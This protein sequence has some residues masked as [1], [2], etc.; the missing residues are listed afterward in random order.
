VS[1]LGIAR[2]LRGRRT[3]GEIEFLCLPEDRGVIAEPVPARTVQPAWFKA[4]PGLDRAALSATNNGLT[5]KRCVPFLDALSIGWIL[6]LA[7]TVRLEI[8]DGGRSVTAGWE[9]DREMVSPHGAH[10][11]AG[12]PYEPRPVMKFHNPWTI[13][14]PKGWSCLFVPPL[15]RPGGIVEVLSGVVDTD[16]YV[17]PVNFPFVALAE[18]GVHTLPKGTPLVQLIPFERDNERLEGSIRVETE[19]EAAERERVYRNTL[20]GEGWYRRESRSRR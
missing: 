12:N 3:H 16:L 2:P 19:A 15:N 1:A 8:S 20:A 11:A 7:A 9:F 18:D 6:P 10:Q 14:T 17:S 13:R 4:L 5:V